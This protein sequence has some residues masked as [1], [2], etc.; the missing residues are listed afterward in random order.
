MLLWN[1]YDVVILCNYVKCDMCSKFK[2]EWNVNKRNW[3][4]RD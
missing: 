2:N 3:Y 4:D 1:I